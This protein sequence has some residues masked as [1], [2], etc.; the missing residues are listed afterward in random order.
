MCK[1]HIYPTI[2]ALGGHE[3]AIDNESKKQEA[4]RNCK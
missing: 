2:A 4:I 1:S 3:I